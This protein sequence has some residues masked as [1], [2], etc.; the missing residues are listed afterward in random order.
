MMRVSISSMIPRYAAMKTVIAITAPVKFSASWRVGQ[1]TLRSSDRDCSKNVMTDGPLLRRAAAS[2]DVGRAP[3]VAVLA[4][5]A[6]RLP[7]RAV[8]SCGVGGVCLATIHLDWSLGDIGARAQAP[9]GRRHGER[10]GR[11]DTT[12]TCNLRFWRPLLY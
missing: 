1:V 5:V 12:R 10:F 9:R 11:P 6:G 3:L 7:A 4:R 8:L 2:A